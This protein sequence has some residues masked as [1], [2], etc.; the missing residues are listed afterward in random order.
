[1]TTPIIDD[2]CTIDDC[3][4]AVD[5]VLF[6]I[7]ML[8]IGMSD[9]MEAL[10]DELKTGKYEASLQTLAKIVMCLEHSHHLLRFV[11]DEQNIDQSMYK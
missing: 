9:W 7:E 1:M 4:T 5:F 2:P 6:H 10:E 3:E 8:I 11:P